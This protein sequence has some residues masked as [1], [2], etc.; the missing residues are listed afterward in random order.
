MS[1]FVN[2]CAEPH[3]LV[4]QHSDQAPGGVFCKGLIKRNARLTICKPFDG[5]PLPDTPN[6]FDGL[7]VLGGPQH[8]TDDQIAPHF[9]QLMKLMR[10]FD[11]MG[12]PVAGICLGCQLLARAYGE[13]LKSLGFLEFGF[14]Q[15]ILTE[16][17]KLDPISHTGFLPPLMEFHEDTFNLPQGATLLIEGSTCR[18]QCFKV[19]NASYGFQFHLEVT[20]AQV[21]KWLELFNSGEISQYKAYRNDFNHAD[22]EHLA[23]NIDGY[24]KDSKKF[25]DTVSGR[26]LALTNQHSRRVINR[27]KTH[28]Y[29]TDDTPL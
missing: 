13:K 9:V 7:V 21:K 15:H 22:F 19:G 10:T 3:I 4:V 5:V 26:W 14:I 25:C 8:A 23:S 6:N 20:T 2:T 27:K 11:K 29:L 1:L 12:K 24:I 16:E 17:G 28:D 18:N